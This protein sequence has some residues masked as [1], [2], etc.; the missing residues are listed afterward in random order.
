MVEFRESNYW[1]DDPN[2]R[3]QQVIQALQAA[4]IQQPF[5][6]GGM[7][8]STVTAP[9][10]P[11]PPQP[12]LANSDSDAALAA[13]VKDVVTQNKGAIPWGPQGLN[14]FNPLQSMLDQNYNIPGTAIP[15]VKPQQ[16]IN[17]Y[18][19]PGLGESMGKGIGAGIGD[20]ANV[21]SQVAQSVVQAA[22]QQNASPMSVYE[23]IRN[24]TPGYSYSGPSAEEM[25]AKQFDPLFAML[26]QQ[27][28]QGTTDY[29]N[30]AARAKQAY[31]G[32]VND[33]LASGKTNAATYAQAGKDIGT[34][35][36]TAS[37]SVTDNSAASAK[38]LSDQ[39]ALLGVQDAAPDLFAKNQQSL[40]TELG[41][42]AQNR[43]NSADLT[44]QLGAN[45]SAFDRN[46]VDV[47]R[48]AGINYQGDVYGR[49]MD[50]MNQNDMQRLQLQGQQGQA[51]N[52][53]SM[54]IEKL[55]SDAANQRETSIND[56]FQTYMQNAVQQGQLDLS[57]DRLA[58]DIDKSGLNQPTDGSNAY[59]TLQSQAKQ[60]FGNDQQAA[61]AAQTLLNAFRTAPQA[62]DIGTLLAQIPEEELRKP[63]MADLAYAFFNSVLNN[64]GL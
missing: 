18:N 20:I 26:S 2:A 61:Q 54:Q 1:Q 63:Y 55:L 34:S 44:T 14:S 41:H 27:R 29:N 31:Q 25:A 51:V 40:N 39:L 23:Q 43:Q 22:N 4:G 15:K 56:Q 48:Q 8:I 47:G 32:F 24:A 46:N 64:K 5:N 16:P 59:R 57:R 6:P 10:P 62:T 13:L 9:A 52:D 19:G 42:L 21:F 45:Q 28:Q 3:K 35:Y 36:N 11:P 33:L 58:F 53:Y 38:A 17:D 12:N 37:K 30:E 50:L 49:Y 60:Y 7:N